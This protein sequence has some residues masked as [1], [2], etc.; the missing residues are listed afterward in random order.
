MPVFLDASKA[1]L[2]S[3]LFFDPP[4]D[5]C[6]RLDQSELAEGLFKRFGVQEMDF[7][8]WDE[9][10]Q[11][12]HMLEM[13]DYARAGV[14]FNADHYLN[15]CVQK[16]TDCILL[17]ASIWYGL[18]YGPQVKG[19]VPNEW[20]VRPAV[21]PRLH[22]FF[23]I[24]VP[25][26][27]KDALGMDALQARARNKMKGRLELLQVRSA[28]TLFLLDHRTAKAFGLPIKTEDDLLGA[29]SRGRPARRSAR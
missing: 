5:R 10:Q 7:G 17:L 2:E 27:S 21:P 11:I 22:L 19:C 9:L 29:P 25:E 24:K 23:V 16:A 18:P 20:H 13:K 8:W 4:H 28:T 12:M 15:E 3:G 14:S 1:H 26:T 6:F